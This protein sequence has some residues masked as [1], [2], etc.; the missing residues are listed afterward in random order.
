MQR[1][2]LLDFQLTG[3]LQKTYE[4]YTLFKFLMRNFAHISQNL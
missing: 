4:Q 1:D 2:T 3:V